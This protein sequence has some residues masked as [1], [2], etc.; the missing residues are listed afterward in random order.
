MQPAL[1]GPSL[2]QCMFTCAWHCPPSSVALLTRLVREL[3]PVLLPCAKCR[4]HFK[5]N[6]RK[7]DA[8]TGGVP[9]TPE[10]T[11]VWL[12]HL[13]NTVNA[14]T[15]TKSIPLDL[16]YERYA[17]HAG[18][19]IDEVQFADT[20]VLVA[21]HAQSEALV[22]EF[23]ETCAIVGQLL[24]HAMSGKAS[25]NALVAELGTVEA[26]VVLGALRVA[27]SVRSAHGRPPLTRSHYMESSR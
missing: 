11:F 4:E 3:I 23:L 16:L 24:S 27:R 20:L 2:W 17:F 15:K 25:S 10:K 21:I 6:C 13:K 12:W 9:R 19:L 18:T 14:S 22:S 26:P 5:N 1:W 8:Q 7:A